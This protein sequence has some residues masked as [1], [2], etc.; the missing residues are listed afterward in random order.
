MGIGSRSAVIESILF[1]LANDDDGDDDDGYDDEGDDNNNK[2][3]NDNNKYTFFECKRMF[4]GFISLES[5]P[6]TKSPRYNQN[7]G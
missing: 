3:N 2:S 5:C 4:L 6:S 1:C 7:W